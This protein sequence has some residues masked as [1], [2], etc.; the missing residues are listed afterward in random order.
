[1]LFNM[2]RSAINL[3]EN[4]GGVSCMIL[5]MIKEISSLSRSNDLV[6]LVLHIPYIRLDRYP[7]CLNLL[8][9]SL[10]MMCF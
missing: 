10:V 6:Y 8:M 2:S 9:S 3:K 4:N 5:S 7:Y 1:M